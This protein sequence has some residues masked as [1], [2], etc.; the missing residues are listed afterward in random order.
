MYYVNREQI[1]VRLDAIAEIAAALD[2][3]ADQ[4]QGTLLE[5]LAQERALHLAIET[6]TDV[7]SFLIDG[8]ILR[9][10]SSYE[11]IIEISGEAGAFPADMQ[12]TLIELVQLRKPLV[13]DYYVW[14]RASLHPLSKTLSTLLPEYKQAVE[15]YLD[16]EL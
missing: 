16:R 2:V 11:D 5:G 3:L 1:A 7:G 13:Q 4:W 15:D 12:S 10:A 6:V 14:E 9:D 8:F